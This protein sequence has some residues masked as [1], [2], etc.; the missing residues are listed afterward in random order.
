M[1]GVGVGVERNIGKIL[2]GRILPLEDVVYLIDQLPGAE[3]QVG[4]VSKP[5][6]GAHCLG[7]Y[8][9]HEL[10]LGRALFGILLIDTDP[11]DPHVLYGSVKVIRR[12]GG[13][14]IFGV[15]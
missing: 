9:P 8:G 15:P 6:Q 4:L 7:I 10:D 11:V 3:A 1:S 5:D 13:V 2:G 12:L 14:A